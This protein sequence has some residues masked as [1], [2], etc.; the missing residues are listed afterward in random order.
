MDDD[1]LLKQTSHKICLWWTSG[2]SV[3]IYACVIWQP[4]FL[5]IALLIQTILKLH[6]GISHRGSAGEELDYYLWG[7]GFDPWDIK[8]FQVLKEGLNDYD[9]N[10]DELS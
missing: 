2:F 10:K 3:L 4:T 8:E 9:E 1:V 7:C 6:T 5:L